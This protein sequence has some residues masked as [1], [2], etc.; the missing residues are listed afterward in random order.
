MVTI[1]LY[2]MKFKIRLYFMKKVQFF[3]GFGDFAEKRKKGDKME[4][5]FHPVSGEVIYIVSEKEKELIDCALV[6]LSSQEGD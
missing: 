4:K 2:M 6:L 1:P 3:I 5:G